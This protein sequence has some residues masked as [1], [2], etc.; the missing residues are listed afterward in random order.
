MQQEI[1]HISIDLIDDPKIAMR[2]DVDDD[3]I[4]ELRASIKAHGLLQPITVRPVGPRFE[5]I[6]GHRRFR[7]HQLGGFAVIACIVREASD[8]ETTVLKMHENLLRR[9]VNVV[10]EACFIGEITT[11]MS[12]TGAELA[13]KIGRSVGYI[14]ARLEVFHMPEY[15]QDHL[16]WNRYPLG[17]AIWLNKIK[18]ES[19]KKYYAEYA[20]LSGCAVGQAQRW[21]VACNSIPDLTPEQA[22]AMRLAG[23]DPTGAEKWVACAK[24]PLPI[25]LT[26]AMYAYTHFVCPSPSL[27]GEDKIPRP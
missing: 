4:D 11:T 21:V 20:A 24:C 3:G 5:V 16:R 18:N 2:S 7:A 14:E 15:M 23:G 27:E 12:I 17:T 6:A 22:E 25:K 19:Q 13:G 10:D 1:K 9:D 8:E 26:D